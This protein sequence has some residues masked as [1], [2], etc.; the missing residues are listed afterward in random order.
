MRE[1]DPVTGANEA[2]DLGRCALG[3]CPLLGDG[4]RFARANQ[5]VSADGE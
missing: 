4:S 1:H 2:D 3:V 5:G